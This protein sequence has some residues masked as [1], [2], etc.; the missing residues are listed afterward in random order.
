MNS[1]NRNININSLPCWGSGQTTTMSS[2]PVFFWAPQKP[3]QCGGI[4][5]VI[6]VS[7]LSMGWSG[8]ARRARIEGYKPLIITIPKELKTQERGSISCPQRNRG[9]FHLW[10][11]EGES[12]ISH[13]ISLFLCFLSVKHDKYLLCNVQSKTLFLGGD[14]TAQNRHKA[15][16]ALSVH[17]KL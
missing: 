2:F 16:E 4:T 6:L 7:N 14:V 15:F 17:P 1:S 10:R 13:F 9:F 8:M 5:L 11:K 12:P 3:L